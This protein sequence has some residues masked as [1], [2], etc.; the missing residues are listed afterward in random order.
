MLVSLSDFKK[1][2]PIEMTKEQFDSWTGNKNEN[3]I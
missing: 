1:G 3:E 2:K